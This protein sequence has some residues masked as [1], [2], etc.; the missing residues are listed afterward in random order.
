M[1]LTMKPYALARQSGRSQNAVA[2][3][4]L[5]LKPGSRRAGARPISSFLPSATLELAAHC[6]SFGDS[7][8]LLRGG[9]VRLANLQCFPANSHLWRRK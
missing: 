9:T 3:L 7:S 4:I 6:K 2:A 1:F 8:G 5:P